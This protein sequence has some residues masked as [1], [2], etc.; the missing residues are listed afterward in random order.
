MDNVILTPHVSGH[1][2]T[3]MED[4]YAASVELLIDFSR[5]IR[6]PSIVNGV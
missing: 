1:T 6:P 4:A 5:G 2:G 3:M